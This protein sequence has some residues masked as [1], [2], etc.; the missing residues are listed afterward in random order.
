MGRIPQI[1]LSLHARWLLFRGIERLRT[2]VSYEHLGDHLRYDGEA[3]PQPYRDEHQ[4][5]NK[6]PH[7]GSIACTKN[8]YE[9]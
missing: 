1:G 4:R 8:Q 3:Q 2:G 9:T 7:F 5:N 6:S